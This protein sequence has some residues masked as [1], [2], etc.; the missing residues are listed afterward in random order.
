MRMLKNCLTFPENKEIRCG[1]WKPAQPL[2][3][4]IARVLRRGKKIGSGEKEG[5]DQLPGE[6]G[7]FFNNKW[8]RS[9]PE[10]DRDFCAYHIKR[11]KSIKSDDFYYEIE[12]FYMR[13]KTGTLKKYEMHSSIH[14][15]LALRGLA[16]LKREE[17]DTWLYHCQWWSCRDPDFTYSRDSQRGSFT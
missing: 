1:R 6:T 13:S 16:L 7:N 3:Y 17:W 10:G 5:K 15:L 4:E 8:Q 11:I 2:G 9:T 12:K 14:I